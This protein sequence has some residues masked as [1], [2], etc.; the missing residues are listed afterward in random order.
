MY[1]KMKS[2]VIINIMLKLSNA[3]KLCCYKYSSHFASIIINNMAYHMGV[4]CKLIKLDRC[5]N[6]VGRAFAKYDDMY[7]CIVNIIH[8]N[9]M[10]ILFVLRS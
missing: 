2:Y 6:I 8:A 5:F 3:Y 1:V 10:V 7:A 9:Y 4:A